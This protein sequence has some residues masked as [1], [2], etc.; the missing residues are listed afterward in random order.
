[1][2]NAK[3]IANLEHFET[4]KRIVDAR[5]YCHRE[6]PDQVFRHAYDYYR[7]NDFG[8]AMSPDFWFFVQDLCR[9]TGESTVLMAVLDPDPQSYFDRWGYYNWIEFSVNSTSE[10]YWRILSS[11]PPGSDGE[12]IQVYSNRVVWLS[13]SMKWAIWG[14]IYEETC[15][16]GSN[17]SFILAY[18]CDLEWALALSL[19]YVYGGTP[20]PL[21]F[22]KTMIDNYGGASDAGTLRE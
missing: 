17:E 20:W 14:D 22:K 6:F 5:V 18:W 15:V 19:T 8:W 21:G 9:R 4:W 12:T 11:S 7:F 13:E 16:V 3:F 10:D 2:S 1:M